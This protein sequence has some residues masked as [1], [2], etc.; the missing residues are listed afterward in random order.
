[1]GD[2]T[3]FGNAPYTLYGFRKGQ[4]SLASD[5]VFQTGIQSANGNSNNITNANRWVKLYLK[6]TNN[7]D[8]GYFS[9]G[10]DCDSYIVGDGNDA[11]SLYR[12]SNGVRLGTSLTVTVTYPHTAWIGKY[13]IRQSNRLNNIATGNSVTG[14]DSGYAFTINDVF[15]NS[16]SYTILEVTYQKY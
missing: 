3:N 13:N 9:V 10:F 14:I 1:M 2:R 7:G 6:V 5:L 4:T 11:V 12:L 16:H 8:A 15:I